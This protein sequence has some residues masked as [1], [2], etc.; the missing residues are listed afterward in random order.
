[1]FRHCGLVTGLC[2][3]PC[4]CYLHSNEQTGSS[5]AVGHVMLDLV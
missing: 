1:M 2:P 3:S 4:M 5:S